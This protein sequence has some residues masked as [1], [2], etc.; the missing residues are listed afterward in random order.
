MLLVFS[1][2]MFWACVFTFLFVINPVWVN[3]PDAM[4]DR[5]LPAPE[6]Y[7]ILATLKGVLP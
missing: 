2:S 5:I 1:I 7:D 6:I 4:P 3:L